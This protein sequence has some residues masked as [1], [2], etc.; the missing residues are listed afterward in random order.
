MN[1]DNKKNQRA[2]VTG[3]TGFLGKHLC[4]QLVQQGWEVF[5]LCRSADKSQELGKGIQVIIGDIL[6]TDDFESDLPQNLDAVFHTAASTN[7]WFKNNQMQNDTNIQGTKNMLNLAE[8]LGVKKFVHVSSV[9]VFGMHSSINNV[10]EDMPKS[11]AD[12]FINYVRT[13]T[14]AEQIVIDN[15]N[16]ETVVINPTHIIGPG[17]KNNWA[18]LI[19][20]IADNKLP[21]IPNGAGSF[22]D[23]RDVASGIIAAFHKGQN[24]QNY[25]LGGTDMDFNQFTDIFAT[26]FNVKLSAPQLPNFLLKVL[27][28]I[29]NL[30]SR[31]TNNEPDIT[32]ESVAI[33]SDLYACDAAKARK[34]L[35]YT[36][37]DFSLTVDDTV[38]FLKE[39]GI[40][41]QS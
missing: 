36:T 10:T 31:I 6:S 40:L 15:K 18:R 20:M 7:T 8:K 13:K 4:S 27:A 14:L 16:L 29:K 11:G 41:N 2:L 23:V 34:Q 32:P 19:K 25:L 30:Q 26:K 21:S 5:A 3:A 37:R 24:S 22:V 1:T 12:S 38:D 17:D 33:I 28:R 9:V 35:G 39:E